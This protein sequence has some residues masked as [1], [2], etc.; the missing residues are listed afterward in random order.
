MLRHSYTIGKNVV[1][2]YLGV[3]LCGLNVGVTE[4]V[5][6]DFDR[7]STAEGDGS[8]EGMAADVCGDGLGD[9]GRCCDGLK[10]TIV[11]VVA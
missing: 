7:Y 4:H 8:S 1:G 10:P 11:Y 9:A 3:D 6:N 2:K 5:A